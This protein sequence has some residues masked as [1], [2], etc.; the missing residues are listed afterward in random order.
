MLAN[1]GFWLIIVGV[2]LM[3]AAFLGLAFSRIG[4]DSPIHNGGGGDQQTR[5]FEIHFQQRAPTKPSQKER[6]DPFHDR[7]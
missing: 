7:R 2:L 4:N 1:P 5:V 3:V 6:P